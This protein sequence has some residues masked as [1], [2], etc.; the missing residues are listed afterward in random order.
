MIE[1]EPTVFIVD[2]DASARR[3]LTRLIRAAGFRAESFGSAREFLASQGRDGPGCLVLDVKMPEMTGPELQVQLSKAEYCMPIIFLSAH[4]DV[5]TTATAMKKGAVDFL[6]KPVDREDLLG[7]IRDSLAKDA[8][9]RQRF[10]GLESVRQRIATLTP[11][12]HEVMTYV[13]TGMLNKQIA[14]EL[15]IAEDTV[16]IHRGRVMQ[17]LSIVSVAELVRLCEMAGIPPAEARAS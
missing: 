15:A 11:R 7:A 2:D 5:P 3:G 1:Q 12:E 9:A 4:G 16:K 17:K 13:I 6:T 10:A 8:A 14:V